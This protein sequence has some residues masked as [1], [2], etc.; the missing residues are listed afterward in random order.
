MGA[1]LAEGKRVVDMAKQKEAAP[2][3]SSWSLVGLPK[4]VA[5][6]FVGVAL[7]LCLV[8]YFGGKKF[9]NFDVPRRLRG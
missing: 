7:V 8:P 1:K 6:F 2:R 3:K 5:I 9:F 4:E